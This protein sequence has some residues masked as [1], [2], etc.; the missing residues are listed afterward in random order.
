MKAVVVIAH[1]AG[2][3]GGRYRHVVE[4]IVPAGYP[5]YAHD[6]RGHGRSQGRRA[7]IDRMAERHRRPRRLHRARPRGRAG[8]GR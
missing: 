2:E 5:V 6:H 8:G 7:V 4:R 3:H 1:G